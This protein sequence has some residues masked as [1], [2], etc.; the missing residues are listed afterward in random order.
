MILRSPSQ[1]MEHTYR[2]CRLK[3]S[4]RT[5]TKLQAFLG[6]LARKDVNGF[7]GEDLD[8][9]DVGYRARILTSEVLVIHASVP[10][11]RL[12]SIVAWLFVVELRCSL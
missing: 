1:V 5:G 6:V 12:R 8:G 7:R 3:R 4:R 9:Q 11:T 2:E 10:L